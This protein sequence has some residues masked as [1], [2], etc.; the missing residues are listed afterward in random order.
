MIYCA[1][2]YRTVFFKQGGPVEFIHH[3]GGSLMMTT[4][5]KPKNCTPPTYHNIELPKNQQSYRK[6][7]IQ[8][9]SSVVTARASISS[10]TQTE[11]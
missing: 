7:R 1:C 2:K 4:Y 6:A 9:W 11:G 8:T 10:S 3:S 5:P